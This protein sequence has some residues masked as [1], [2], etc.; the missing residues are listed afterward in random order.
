M[1]MISLSLSFADICKPTAT[2][3]PVYTN[4]CHVNNMNTVPTSTYC[5]KQIRNKTSKVQETLKVIHV[6]MFP[7]LKRLSNEFLCMV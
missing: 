1:N 5:F 4:E 7:F 3:R 6:I 2:K